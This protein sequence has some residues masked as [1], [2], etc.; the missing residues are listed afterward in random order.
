MNSDTNLST[1]PIATE[2]VG[3]PLVRGM[4][5]EGRVLKIVAFTAVLVLSGLS[6]PVF[7]Q[8]Q[9]PA[10]Q[11]APN[12]S[13]E[14]QWEAFGNAD[15]EFH[16]RLPATPSVFL[17]RRSIADITGRETARIYKAYG[18]GLVCFIV[19]YDQTQNEKPFSLDDFISDLKKRFF[20][21]WDV[22][23]DHR[24]TINTDNGLQYSVKKREISGVVRFFVKSKHSYMAAVV[25][26]DGTSPKVKQFLD[27]FTMWSYSIDK[28]RGTPRSDSDPNNSATMASQ[29]ELNSPEGKPQIRGNDQ[30]EYLLPGIR[31]IATPKSN[32]SDPST[33]S[34]NGFAQTNAL[35]Y[36]ERTFDP[37]EVTSK[38]FVVIKPEPIYTEEARDNHIEGVVRLRGVL[39]RDGSVSDVSVVQ[40]L[41]YGLTESA[42]K[43]MR[44]LI[45]LPASK[46]EHYVSQTVAVEFTFSLN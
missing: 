9:S 17:I 6:A 20:S 46:D 11:P 8:D 3:P 23:F 42:I 44:H 37:S 33:S 7:A 14:S 31:P 21:T 18:E 22:R 36:Y 15:D 1:D 39:T 29:R 38:A 5:E 30:Q 41:P 40:G 24:I 19:V 10:F 13:E 26:A 12:H 28:M 45:F 4:R 16:V 2:Q 25:G 32:D 27:S 34:Q 43:A 35:P